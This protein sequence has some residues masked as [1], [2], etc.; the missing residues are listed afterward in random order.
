MTTPNGATP[1]GSLGTGQFAAW[2]AMTEED[3]KAQMRAPVDSFSSAQT[4]FQGWLGALFSG[5]ANLGAFLTG[6]TNAFTG[7]SSGGGLFDGIF[8][9]ANDQKQAAVELTNRVEQLEGGGTRTTYAVASTWTNPGAGYIVSIACING[10]QGGYDGGAASG[11]AKGGRGGVGGG[12]VEET[13]NSE[14][15]SSTVSVSPGAGGAANGGLGGVS[16]FGS[17]VAGIRGV[18]AIISSK[19]ALETSS[20]PGDGGTGGDYFPGANCAGESGGSSALAAGGAGGAGSSTTTRHAAAGS[21]PASDPVIAA[22]GG[23]GGGGGTGG[24]GAGGN[25]GG[26]IF[27][28]GGGGG[29]AGTTGNNGDGGLGGAGRVIVTVKART[30]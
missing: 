2:Q 23:G 16:T 12:W 7:T 29:G 15:L 20:K 22:G 8:N 9:H 4:G 28:S 27:G 30:V 25:G 19:G 14:D 13:F 17:Y 18:G 10:G 26:G 21:G 11:G 6:L 24:V 3:A 5:F 1:D